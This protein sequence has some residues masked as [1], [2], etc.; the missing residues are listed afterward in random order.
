GYT[1][2]VIEH[3]MD[4]VTDTCD[5]VI[6]LDHG[7]KIAE[8]TPAEVASNP[9]V[10]QAYLGAPSA[11]GGA[12]ELVAD[13]LVEPAG[14]R[15][16]PAV[17]QRSV[18]AQQGGSDKPSVEPV[19]ELKSVHSSYGAVR[20]LQGVDLQVNSGEIVVVLGSNAAGKSTMLK[21][22]LGGV[23]PS[24]GQIIFMGRRIDALPTS[25]IARA[26]IAIVPEG[27]R[28]FPGLT[29]L[30]N[31]ELGGYVL[32]DR[33]AIAQSVDRIFELFPALAERRGQRAGTLSGGEQQMLAISRALVASPRLICMDEPSMGLAP[34]L[35]DRVMQAILDI[36]RAGMTVLLV[37]QN[38]RAALAIADRAYILRS[39]RVVASGAA[40]DFLEDETV[41]R[42]YLS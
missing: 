15:R 14:S 7:E 25:E 23:R 40:S 17:Q 22:I 6:V 20:A 18:A 2:L 26:G 38:A 8:G 30:E 19:L 39:G 27:R 3:H 34:I 13:R 5:R 9:E 1:V 36:N 11:S 33:R 29:V 12:A 24:S 10:M 31:L 41:A 28:I 4:V 37:E 42:A 21:T 35:I 16:R 32:Q